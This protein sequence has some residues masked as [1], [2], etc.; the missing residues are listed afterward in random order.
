MVQTP[1]A[2]TPDLTAPVVLQEPERPGVDAWAAPDAVVA[3][4]SVAASPVVGLHPGWAAV[5]A[6]GERVLWQGQPMAQAGLGGLAQV[7]SGSVPLLVFMAIGLF[8]LI[9]TGIQPPVVFIVLAAMVLIFARRKQK[10]RVAA[11]QRYLLTNRSAYLARARGAALVDFR[12]YPITADMPL[13]LGPQSVSFAVQRMADGRGTTT[14]QAVGFT[15]IADAADVHA[16]IR[17]IQKGAL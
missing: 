1:E 9:N 14:E 11:D 2:P 10:G 13:G 6:P 8:I 5:I 17:D 7:F 3:V 12:A 16:M 15:D 4:P